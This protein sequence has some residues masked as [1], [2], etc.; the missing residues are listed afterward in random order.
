MAVTHPEQE[1]A[2]EEEAAEEEADGEAEPEE[3]HADGGPWGRVPGG[4]AP[5]LCLWQEGIH[6][7]CLPTWAAAPPV[8][9]GTQRSIVHQGT[10]T[11]SSFCVGEAWAQGR[12]A[13]VCLPV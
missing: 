12:R 11:L 8:W 2:G 7:T 9:A 5:P 10:E 13:C 6:R 1:E 3:T 4:W